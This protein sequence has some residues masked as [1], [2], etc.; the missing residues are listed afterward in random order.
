MLVTCSH[1]SSCCTCYV[2]GNLFF[3]N[4]DKLKMLQMLWCTPCVFIY[5][6]PKS[7]HV[8]AFVRVSSYD[9]QLLVAK[10]V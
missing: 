3:V 5:I 8:R 7:P 2:S 6:P 10:T 4:N 9:V 1:G